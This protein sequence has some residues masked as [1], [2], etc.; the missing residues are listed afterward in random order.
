MRRRHRV[1]RAMP[2]AL[3]EPPE[4]LGVDG[5]V[6]FASWA[7]WVDAREVFRLA[8]DPD[9][10]LS[11]RREDEQRVWRRMVDRWGGFPPLGGRAAADERERAW[12]AAGGPAW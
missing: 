2:E 11:G 3:R 7:S 10:A 12:A 5:E 9:R 8:R 1:D 4:L 6:D